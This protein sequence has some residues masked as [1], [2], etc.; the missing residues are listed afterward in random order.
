MI[1]KEDTDDVMPKSE[2]TTQTMDE[3]LPWLF[4]PHSKP[5]MIPNDV[6]KMD[7]FTDDVT[8]MDEFTDDVTKMDEIMKHQDS[9][10]TGSTDSSS[11]D[12]G[13]EE[14]L[15]RLMPAEDNT[16]ESSQD[17]FAVE[18]SQDDIPFEDVSPMSA[19]KSMQKVD[20]T[21]ETKNE[22]SG[23]M[24]HDD[25][26][27]DDRILPILDE[28]EDRLDHPISG[29]GEN[30]QQKPEEGIAGFYFTKLFHD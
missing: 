18:P 27:K 22:M 6:T 5:E 9:M 30:L 3:T 21:F 14:L 8:K 17:P 1:D 19:I 10:K 28:E 13:T 15:L 29:S 7:E 4:Q 20:P 2:T 25:H 26:T 11:D 16:E 12:L 24:L 23:S